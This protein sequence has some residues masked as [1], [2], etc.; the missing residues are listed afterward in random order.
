MQ[1]SQR[2]IDNF[3]ALSDRSARA[4]A[5]ALGQLISATA[6]DRS[7]AEQS[8]TDGRFAEVARYIGARLAEPGL[9]AKTVAAALGVSARTL[10]ALFASKGQTMGE[11]VRGRRLE[12]C[13][14]TLMADPDRMVSEVALSWGFSSVPSF[15]RAF[16]ARFGFAPGQVRAAARPP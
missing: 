2:V 13:R 5:T 12:E 15:Y 6:G 8:R 3:E 10:S 9:S 11:Y 16:H 7:E 14:H 1:H 4:A